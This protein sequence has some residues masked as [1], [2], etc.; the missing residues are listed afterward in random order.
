MGLFTPTSSGHTGLTNA[1]H[2]YDRCRPL[3][4]FAQVNVWVSSLL[5]LVAAVLSLGLFGAL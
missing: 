2:R 4:G 5:S 3:L 1:S